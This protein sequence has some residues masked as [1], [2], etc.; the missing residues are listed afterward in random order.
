MRGL[1]MKRFFSII[2]ILSLILCLCACSAGEGKDTEWWENTGS[3]DSSSETD[4]PSS[5]ISHLY[6]EWKNEQG[7]REPIDEHTVGG[8]A[9]TVKSVVEDEYGN[10]TATL[11]VNSSEVV[12]KVYR[13]K[14]GYA[15]YSYMEALVGAKGITI[16]YTK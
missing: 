14:V 12:Y 5:P 15:E 6:G 13:Y 11:T 2:S 8:S 1:K 10:I 16:V 9:Y 4:A 7:D 3:A